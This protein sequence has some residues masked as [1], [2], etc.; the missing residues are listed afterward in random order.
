MHMIERPLFLTT[1]LS[2]LARLSISQA[3]IHTNQPRILIPSPKSES[4][5]KLF[6]QTKRMKCEEGEEKAS[7]LISLVPAIGNIFNASCGR[8]SNRI[9]IELMPIRQA[10]R[11]L[12]TVVP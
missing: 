2:H 5:R 11:Q 7:S 6:P 10:G 8:D 12:M 9:R 1:F 3:Y 4:E